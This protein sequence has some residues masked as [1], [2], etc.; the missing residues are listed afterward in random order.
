[1][2]MTEDKLLKLEEVLEQTKTEWIRLDANRSLLKEQ[3][4]NK[5]KE[6]AE[7]RQSAEVYEKARILLQQ[8]AE[9]AREQAKQQMETLVS[10]ALQ[11]VFGPLF[12]FVIEIEEQG[13]KAVAEFYVV[14]EYEGIKVKTRPQDSRGGGVVDIVTLALR[15]ALLETVQP[16][17]NGALL[18]DEPGKH[19][20][21]E[22]V[23]LLYDFLK[24]LSSMF[25]R[26][27]IMI[28]HNHHLAESAD[29]A[30]QVEIQDGISEVAILDRP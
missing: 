6:L 19:V 24:S 29:Q 2:E 1:M 20:S 10:N 27:V 23:H 13:N 26:Q 7:Y 28:T 25:D 17:L 16:K 21:D 8:S 12:S 11:Y 3:L 22:Y 14:S 9:Y 4:Q 5:E 30:Y 18:L 15:I